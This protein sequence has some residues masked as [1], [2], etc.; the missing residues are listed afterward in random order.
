MYIPDR[1]Y[2]SKRDYLIM[3]GDGNISIK[4]G[5]NV[6]GF[7]LELFG[8]YELESYNPEN[9]SMRY[10]DNKVIGV[11]M[12]G[13]ALGNEPFLKY[14]GRLG[15]RKCSV[16]TKQHKTIYLYPY[17]DKITIFNGTYSKFDSMA[18]KWE[19]I[20]PTDTGKIPIKTKAYFITKN[21][22]T[23]GNQYILNGGDYVGDY[24]IHQDGKV[25]SGAEHT[26]SSQRLFSRTHKKDLIAKGKINQYNKSKIK[27]NTGGGY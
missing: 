19:D 24:H 18:E 2:I 23:K 1:K 3:F 6:L 25:M 20:K 16:L 15:I 17:I 8:K 26:D 5:T 13:A 22:F 21:L 27:I 9:F 14:K 4:M 12:N 10:N 7:E 11:S